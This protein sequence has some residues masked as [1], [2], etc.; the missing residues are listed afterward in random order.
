MEPLGLG[1]GVEP[2]P[3]TA[4]GPRTGRRVRPAPLATAGVARRQRLAR[5]VRPPGCD[6]GPGDPGGPHRRHQHGR[7]AGGRNRRRGALE[8]LVGGHSDRH[9]GSH[10]VGH[11]GIDRHD[12][13]GRDIQLDICCR[14]VGELRHRVG[15]L[16]AVT[17][18]LEPAT[19]FF[20]ALGTSA[21]VGVAD[22]SAAEAAERLLRRTL[23]AFDLA[24]SRFR[25]DSEITALERAAGEPRVVGGLLFDALS[26]AIEVARLT[27][28][29]VDP[30][31]GGCLRSLGYDRDFGLVAL[32]EACAPP[33][34]LRAGGAP[35]RDRHGAPVPAPGW[36][37]VELDASRRTVR[38][39]PGTVL[40]LGSTAKA[41]AADAAAA[42]I[43]ATTGSGTIVSLGG[44]VAVAGAAP[45]T[46]W[47]VGLATSSSATGADVQTT[48]TMGAGGLAS[49]S[50]GVRAW[51]PGGSLHHIVDPRTGACAP[52][53][54]SLASAAAP[55]CVEANA[56]TTAAL[57]WGEEAPE[58]L[59][60]L[61]YPARLVRDD[62]E[63]LTLNGWS[64]DVRAVCLP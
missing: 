39:D 63:V 42:L 14:V 49:S 52:V 28:G 25:E 38:I 54:W 1:G 11:V 19:R 3:I 12:V 50:A 17:T 20:R 51:G 22:P 8:R 30:T 23:D 21:L 64:H 45:G 10:G 13:G 35:A 7:T 24:C 9:G 5:G 31:V 56:A 61:G 34:S 15:R 55:T 43:A 32:D 46:G 18:A 60:R 44:D 27:D 4:H 48:L 58:M 26:I 33:A 47:S 29:A 40:D 36:R 6:R 53:C 37:T 59:S 16:R 2:E 41:F 57:V 62:G